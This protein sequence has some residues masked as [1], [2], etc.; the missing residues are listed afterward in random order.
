MVE[1]EKCKMWSRLKYHKPKEIFWAVLSLFIYSFIG[2]FLILSIY[3]IDSRILP[4][5][6]CIIWFS[7]MLFF[8]IIDL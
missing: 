2:M 3:T 8:I 6:L 7:T 5:I 4:A 1:C